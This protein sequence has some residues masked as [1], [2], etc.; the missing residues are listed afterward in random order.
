MQEMFEGA[1]TTHVLQLGTPSILS[2]AALA[3]SVELLTK[4]GIDAIYRRSQALVN[5]L[6]EIV[7]STLLTYGIKLVTPPVRDQRGG[8][9]TL[10]HPHGQALSQ[11]LRAYGV[12]PDFRHPDMVRLSPA[13]AFTRFS[14]CAA[15]CD[16]LEHILR[17]GIWQDFDGHSSTVT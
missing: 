11:A 4:A 7:Q 13:P 6:E 15:A 10:S 12:V 17:E 8:H 16:R 1:D 5:F 14:E 9:I 3:G 2:L